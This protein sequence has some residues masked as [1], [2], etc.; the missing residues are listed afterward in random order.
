MNGPGELTQHAVFSIGI[1][2]LICTVVYLIPRMAVLGTS[3]L[4][5]YLGGA[6]ATRV[7]IGG[8]IIPPMVAGVLI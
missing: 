4:T 3:L 8:P 5:G 6:V 1:L 2:E 7:R